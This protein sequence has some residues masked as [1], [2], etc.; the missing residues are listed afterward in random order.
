[1]LK[2]SAIRPTLRSQAHLQGTQSR[3]HRSQPCKRAC[4]HQP[5]KPTLLATLCFLFAIS[6]TGQTQNKINYDIFNRQ[7][8]GQIIIELPKPAQFQQVDI[9]H[10]S[11]KTNQQ[12]QPY[13]P[14][15]ILNGQNSIEQQNNQLLR[16]PTNAREV[17]AM[18]DVER[19]LMQEKFYRDYLE[20]MKKTKSYQEAFQTLS[21][22]NP[23]SF[24]ISKAVFT[25]ENAYY[26]NKLSYASLVNALNERATLVKQILKRE[27]LSTKNNLAL[28]YGI[29]KLFS[30]QNLFYNNKTKQNISIPKIGYDF[31]DF[32][33]KKDWSKMFVWKLLST[34][35]GQCHSL[36]LEY[37][38]I[39]EQLNAK[40]YLSLAPEHSFIKF[41][42]K[43]GNIMSFETTNGNLVSSTWMTQS[44]YITSQALENKMYLDTLSRKNLYA[45]MLGDL[46]LGYL[47]KFPYDGFAEQIKQRILQINPNNMAALITDANLKTQIAAQEIKAA[48]KPKPE[49][50]HNFPEAYGAYM[51]MQAAYDKLN[52][53]GFQDMPADA[54]QRWLKSIDTEKKKQA[55]QQLKAQMQR[56]IQQLKNLKTTLKN[57]TRD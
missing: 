52:S 57:N 2:T 5:H 56:E 3:P 36:P 43:N 9:N 31:D 44:G 55:S 40:A 8:F 48:G 33:G 27:G 45:Q 20:W 15:Q 17:Q 47:S 42:D 35:K 22:L 7:P 41:A 16:Q 37:L 11:P 38:M 49:D 34:N 50:L 12:T 14:D 28:N 25:V 24:S 51:N 19:D 53:L 21:K 23:D 1:V 39:A 10:F 4:L 18:A 13:S 29:Q 30:Q 32:M 6:A 54:Y 26:D 46:L